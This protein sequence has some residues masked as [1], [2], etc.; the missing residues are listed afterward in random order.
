MVKEGIVLGPK[1]SKSGIK[2]DRAKVDVIAKLPHPTTVK[3][4]RSFLGHAGFYRRFIQDFSKISRPMTH[5][6]EKET[7]FV[8]SKECVEA[9]N[10][11]KKKLTEAPIL[12]APDWDLP[13]EIM[14]DA[15]DFAVGAVLG[16]RA[17]NLAA[18]RL[19]RLENPHQSELEKK[20]IIE[21]FPLVTLGMVTFRG[22]ASTPWFADFANYHAENFVVK[23]MSSQQKKKFFK[24]VKHYFWD[25]PYL[26]KV[27]V[28][29]VIRRCV[30]GQEAHDIL[31]A[32][33]DGPTR[34]HHG[35]NYTAKKPL[36]R[37][38][39]SRLFT[40]MPMTWS[41]GVTLVNVKEK[42]YKGMKCHKM[43][44][45]FVRSLTFGASILW[46]RSRLHEGRRIDDYNFDPERDIL[47]LEKLLNDDPSSPLPPKE[48]NFK[49]LKVIKSNVSMDFEDDYYDSEGDIIYLESLLIKDTIPNLHPEVVLDRDP[50]SLEDEPDKD[51]LKNIVKVFDLGI[52]EIIFS[53]TYVKLP[54]EDRH[55]LSLTYFIRI[56]LPYFT[57]PVESSFLLSSESEDTIFDPGIFAF[58]FFSRTGGISSKW[59]FHVLQCLSKHIE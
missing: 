27:C 56:F 59:N 31:M 19:S 24:D 54:F 1:I 37:D 15:S 44:C 50:R 39:I 32:C 34:G 42:S 8:F 11:L 9:F 21:T 20:E 2:V 29:Q 41:H 17:K 4:V 14:C 52:W 55:Y 38:F 36:I 53:P 40:K 10:A 46:D 23:G 6:L 26:F 49:E 48:L 28:D 58:H 51:D 18:D 35:A 25:D 16:Q 5:L 3:G 22:D 30:F 33:H 43:Q 47:L 57:Y 12:V 13:F 45:K 7:P